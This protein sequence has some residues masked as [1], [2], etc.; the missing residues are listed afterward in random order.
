M[1]ALG[2]KITLG[3]VIGVGMTLL[4]IGAAEVLE[5]TGHSHWKGPFGNAGAILLMPAVASIMY[6]AGIRKRWLPKLGN[7]RLWLQAHI[8]MALDR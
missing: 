5:R 1:R 6:I 4:A 8:I 2:R 7:A 3:I